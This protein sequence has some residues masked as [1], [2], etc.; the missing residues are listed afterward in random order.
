MVLLA[1][2]QILLSRYSNQSDFAIG[3]PTASRNQAEL[4]QIVGFFV[5]TQ[6]YKAQL[7][8]QLSV[9]ELIE[10]IRNHTLSIL[11]QEQLPLEW[12]LNNL[13]ISRSS[14]RSPL[15]QVLFDYKTEELLSAKMDDIVI[16]PFEADTTSS[17]LEL[18]LNVLM[19]ESQ[20][21]ISLNYQTAL[22]TQSTIENLLEDFSYL[23]TQ[24]IS[25]PLS[26]L[27]N[28]TLRTLGS[29]LTN[30]SQHKYTAPVHK[31]IEQQVELTPNAIALVFEEEQLTYIE[32]NQRANQLAHY[33]IAQGVK[34]ED[35]VGIAVERSIEM[36]TSLLAVVKTGAV[37][38]P[39]DLTHPQERLAYII[40]DS[41]M[42]RLLTMQSAS[43][44]F[45][46]LDNIQ[47]YIL[48]TLDLS[49]YPV[50]A[51]NVS[52][53][54]DSLVYIIYT[55]G[56]TGKPKG[57]MITHKGLSNYLAYAALSYMREGEVKGS[58]VSSSLTFD[59]T[60]TSLFTPL[61]SGKSVR[62]LSD[63]DELN[64]LAQLMEAATEPL[65]F[66]ITPAHLD[67]LNEVFTSQHELTVE[68]MFIVGGDKLMASQVTT[69]TKILSN[70]TLI[71]EYG[72]TETVVG[73]SAYKIVPSDNTTA[74]YD[75]IPISN[76][77]L[78]TSF[79]ILDSSLS[80]VPNGVIGELCISGAGLARGYLNR[81]DLTASSFIADPFNEE[82]GRLYRTGDLVRWNNEGE[83]EYLGRI[84]HQ[85]KIRGFRIELGEIEAEL[86][87]QAA[88][89]EAVVVAKESQSGTRLVAYVSA[90]VDIALDTNELKIALGKVLPDYMVPSVVVLLDALPLNPNGKIDRKALPEPE[91]VIN[92]EY[93]APIG[94]V[95][96]QLALIWCEVLGIE[97]V[98][99]HDNFF[100]LGGDSILT[101]KVVAK[102]RNKDISLSPKLLFEQQS[103]AALSEAISGEPKLAE[104]PT[105]PL[106]SL[107]QKQRAELSFSQARQ[108]FLWQLAPESTAYHIS[109]ALNLT[110]TLDVNVFKASFKGLV[111]RHESLRT[112]FSDNSDGSAYQ[113]IQD[114]LLLDMPVIDL[115][116]LKGEEQAAAAK[117][118]ALAWHATPFDLTK[119][120]LL[121]V[122]LILLSAD[123]HVLVVV[124]HHI[125]SD[126][127]SMQVLVNEFVARYQAEVEGTILNL[128]ELPIQYVDYAVWQRN[129]LEAGELEKQ[130]AYWCE[131]LGDEQ[132][133]LQLPT[134]NA[135]QLD[136][137][138]TEANH[139]F[140][141]SAE[142]SKGLKKV[143]GQYQSTLFMTLLSAY[144]TLLYRYTG[145]E[146]I[147]IGVPIANR[148]RSEVENIVGFFVNTQVLRAVVHGRMLLS[149]VL[150]QAKTTALGAQEHQDLPFEK[151]VEAL[152][153]ER[154]LSHTPLFQVMYNHQ[155]S[156]DTALAQV[157]D[158]S[159]EGY[160]LGDKG[161]QFE[162][163]LNTSESESG[164]ISVNFSYAKELFES[165]TIVRQSDYYLAIL[166]ALV[167]TPAQAIGDIKLLSD[168]ENKQLAQWGVNDTRYDNT[169][170]VHK[171]IEQQV[172][173]TPSATALV[174]KDEQLTYSELNQRANQLA[175][176]LIAQGVQPEDKVGIAV[177]RSINMVVSLLA[178]LKAGAAFVPL[179]PSYPR[180]R[181]AYMI[182]DSGLTVLLSQSELAQKFNQIQYIT[183]ICIDIL[184]LDSELNTN[185]NV[186]LNKHNLAYLIYT[187]GSTGKPK[188]VAISH[189]GFAEHVLVSRDL[190]C[191]ISSDRKL[192]FST[193][194]FDA[195]I[196]QIF[197]P[198]LVGAG[199]VLRGAELWDAEKCYRELID[200]RIT[201]AYFP[202]AYWFMLI[203]YFAQQDFTDYGQLREMRIGGEAMPPEGIKVWQ[204]A[205]LGHVT[206]LNT[207]G[208]TETIVTVSA[209]D[210]QPYISGIIP[211]PQSMPIGRPLRGRSF[212]VFD[213]SLTP[214]PLGV[215]GELYIGGD[216]LARCYLGRA[217]LTSASFI[218]DPLSEVGGRLYR[219]GDLVRWKKEGEL[220]YLGRIDHQVKI[221][222]FRIELGEIEAEL[223]K[224][225]NVSETVVVAKASQSGTK[226]VA[227][228]STSADTAVDINELKIALGKV[229]PDY[230]VPSVIVLLEALPLNPNGK[231]D[232]KALPEPEF[233][234]NNKYTAPEGEV[235]LILASIWAEVLEV[236]KVGRHNNFFELGGHSL[237]A[238]QVSAMLNKRCGY[239]MPVRYLFEAPEL[240]S[241]ALLLPKQLSEQQNAKT[242]R[243]AQ[244]AS[245]FEEF[246]I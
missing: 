220:E 174:F 177:E 148:H 192:Q 64:Q 76:P 11:E 40:Q 178:V 158:L 120:P 16:T 161:A 60:V 21:Q 37:Y 92:N 50:I 66:K 219:T 84:D 39:I 80:K 150:Q 55:S 25:K 18:E 138:Y 78:S 207:Y 193:I 153:P 200:K 182:E 33:L 77:I 202:T 58:V 175:H 86:L 51:P 5:N 157:P 179:D 189:I 176:Y 143:A 152:Q 201:V 131:H 97:Q 140:T 105:I 1:T 106:L 187:S 166:T 129:W 53:S 230:M 36:V 227:Y 183:V 9:K 95:E 4:Q 136:A 98:G 196:E 13:E 14:N 205:N 238:M 165:E 24:V 156:D 168:S 186:S 228:V 160:E 72:P 87:K 81:T 122:G 109:G 42:S 130:L 126:G 103:I 241:L 3:V 71:N 41:G 102:A 209:S 63:G 217:D 206:L 135:R 236:K 83:L 141:L 38:V 215:V 125:I 17:K 6:V 104:Y 100:E 89:S 190:S 115:S 22:F 155:R 214:V 70:T 167:E 242:A 96:A 32:L 8:P 34:P 91:F 233:V 116:T 198:L 162:L 240:K 123:K 29:V 128:P 93:Q 218:A 46:R 31:L 48:D 74:N 107:V 118:Q 213:S 164:E 229:L 111:A 142:L 191:L 234:S 151:L 117:S 114:E 181:L 26:H 113:V 232:R 221:R 79:V 110:G 15:F 147:R 73:C 61:L 59:A 246:E 47:T 119:G 211:L 94:E 28:L 101:L 2:W 180:E 82:G 144:Q 23:L 49:L 133:I 7:S 188:A 112:I 237:T 27:G 235:E 35:K 149:D 195:S 108:W 194:N 54:Q 199:V 52:F 65:L 226:L 225:E 88:V 208:P 243:I 137:D 212:Y 121:R 203:Q 223:L 145:Q 10:Q 172:A 171:L 184:S 173:L 69:I 159:I 57:T 56:S 30:E 12:L 19:A 44:L 222:G 139:G 134:D 75:V 239:E 216:L 185:L 224:R 132:P 85:V 124:M 67:G 99:R 62:L 210:C 170:P 231:I 20:A 43:G 146:D 68:H 90:S 244:M 204:A 163:T 169:Q 245:L 45:V 154:S 197:S 127:W